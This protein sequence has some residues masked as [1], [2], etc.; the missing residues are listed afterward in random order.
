[1]TITT[2]MDPPDDGE[3]HVDE[4]LFDRRMQALSLR[5][6]GMT[7]SAIAKHFS[8]DPSTVRRDVH[9]ARQRVGSQDIDAIIN[10]QRSVVLD[11]RRANYPAALRGD[12]D[13][14]SNILKGLDHEAKLLGLYAPQRITTGP[15]QAEFSQRAADLI[16]AISPDTLKEILRGT[17]YDPNVIGAAEAGRH[18]GEPVDAEIVA[19][20]DACAPFAG[21]DGSWQPDLAPLDASAAGATAEAAPADAGPDPAD[22]YDDW[23]NID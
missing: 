3:F 5:N 16:A 10:T 15:S 8:I 18:A 20:P 13:A 17:S 11:L 4:A 6:G 7:Y 21:P 12:K 2:I 22:D 1:M 9:W 19:D 23:S 14:A